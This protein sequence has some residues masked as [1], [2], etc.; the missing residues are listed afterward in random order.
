MRY[1]ILLILVSITIHSY[2][3]PLGGDSTSIIITPSNIVI[4]GF[5]VAKVA[6]HPTIPPP[7]FGDSSHKSIFVQCDTTLDLSDEYI[8]LKLW[9]LYE[10]ECYKDSVYYGGWE[11]SG[12]IE[13]DSSIINNRYVIRGI[14]KLQYFGKWK[15]DP[16]TGEGF[17]RWLYRRALL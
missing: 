5:N 12:M 11:N 14:Q 9:L 16:P 7:V 6:V 15:H 17:K 10:Q 3:Q 2:T 8:A 1:F 13:I 4:N